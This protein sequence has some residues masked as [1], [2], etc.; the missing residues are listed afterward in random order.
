VDFYFIFCIPPRTSHY[1]LHALHISSE[2][3][4]RCCQGDITAKAWYVSRVGG[5]DSEG[6]IGTTWNSNGERNILLQCSRKENNFAVCPTVVM[7]CKSTKPHMCTEHSK[8]L[9]IRYSKCSNWCPSCCSHMWMPECTRWGV[10]GVRAARSAR[11]C[12]VLPQL[13]TL[14]RYPPFAAMSP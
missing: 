2:M 9:Y 8:Y 12:N 11:A 7:C 5:S 3:L 1:A 6:G 10:G 13:A 14:Q 4:R